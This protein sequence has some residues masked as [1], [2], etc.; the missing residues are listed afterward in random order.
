MGFNIN[1]K[2]EAILSFNL[3]ILPG[4]SHHYLSVH[5]KLE[6]SGMKHQILKAASSSV[7]CYDQLAAPKCY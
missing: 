5:V 6:D 3:D 7:G 1:N 2:K 4:I